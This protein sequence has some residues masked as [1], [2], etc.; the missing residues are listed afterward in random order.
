MVRDKSIDEGGIVNPVDG[1]GDGRCIKKTSS[2]RDL[3]RE[4]IGCVFS[5]S[6][7][8][9]RTIG[10]VRQRPIHV[11]CDCCSRS[12]TNRIHRADSI[13]V[14]FDDGQWIHFRICVVHQDIDI[15]RGIFHGAGGIVHGIGSRQY[16]AVFQSFREKKGVIDR[17]I[18]ERL[19]I[20]P[21]FPEIR[22]TFS[23]V[24]IFHVEETRA[25]APRKRG[26]TC[27]YPRG[28]HMTPS[29]SYV[30]AQAQ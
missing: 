6:E 25:D 1:N 29:K 9:K 11:K 24:D 26:S 10:V 19:T 14:D 3:V 21:V 18:S 23:P 16:N 8:I 17:A 7:R 4:G 12:Q 27:S 20:E 28:S 5:D 2:V 13:T 15:D 30:G 22:Q